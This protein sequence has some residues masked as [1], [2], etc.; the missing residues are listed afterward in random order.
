MPSY[1]YFAASLPML[2]KDTELPFSPEEFLELCSMHLTAGDYGIVREAS[3]EGTGADVHPVLTCWN[4]FSTAVKKELAAFRAEKI[5][6]DQDIYAVSF[7][8]VPEAADI[9][10]RVFHAPNPLDA[11]TLLL[12]AQWIY[13]DTL[14]T[15]H[16]FDLCMII[17][18][19]IKL[20]LLKRLSYRTKD[21]GKEA[22]SHV[23]SNIQATGQL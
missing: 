8:Q 2:Q 14:G 23:F 19:Y 21:Q 11:A 12:D 9:A 22:F 7:R 16:F 1:Y 13:L 18:Y 10:K 15:N 20:Q 4:E 5:G 3:A 17:V 6:L